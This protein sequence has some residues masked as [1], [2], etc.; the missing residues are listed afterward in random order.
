MTVPIFDHNLSFWYTPYLWFTNSLSMIICNT[1]D[2]SSVNCICYYFFSGFGAIFM[3]MASLTTNMNNFHL[4]NRGKVV[5]I[6]DASFSAGPALMSFLYGLLF[7][8]GHTNDQQNQNLKGFYMTCAILYIVVGCL[9]M[10]FLRMFPEVLDTEIK[11]LLANE[12]HNGEFV[13]DTTGWKLFKNFNFQFIL[14]SCT[15]A[16]SLQLMVQSNIGTYLKSFKLVKYTTLF[17]TINP[18]AQVV[19]KFVAGF[20]SDMLLNRLPRVGV[21]MAFTILQSVFLIFCI[22]FPGHFATLLFLVIIIGMGNGA[23]WCITPTMTSEY[24]GMKYFGRNWGFIMFISGLGGLAVQEVYG[25]IYE[26]AIPYKD[27]KDCYGTQCFTWSFI[28][29]TVLSFC[30]S[31]FYIGLFQNKIKNTAAN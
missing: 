18:I 25:W 13:P 22:F 23:L 2:V 1:K 20:L 29:A 21:L 15:F 8:E 27:D 10:L 17:T 28:M 26:M 30:S 19:S 5:G 16:S 12:E 6:L 3:Y 9:G 24:Y 7:A 31:L 4:K 14:W 11:E